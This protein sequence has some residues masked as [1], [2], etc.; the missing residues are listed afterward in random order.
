MTGFRRLAALR[1][2]LDGGM[3]PHY[4]HRDMP[5]CGT[6]GEWGTWPRRRGDRMRR[7]EFV[8]V[9]GSGLRMLPKLR[10]RGAMH[11]PTIAL[12]TLLLAM[13]GS[14]AT[15]QSRHKTQRLGPPVATAMP[16]D[17]QAYAMRI[18]RQTWPGRALCDDGG[19]RI[20]PCD[21]GKR[22]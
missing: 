20:R 17:P 22:F 13:T 1:P 12:L 2:V 15:A 4:V 16:E 10:G 11:K 5:M 6:G 7:R 3:E 18:A 9:H 21:I 8:A 14:V 19:Y